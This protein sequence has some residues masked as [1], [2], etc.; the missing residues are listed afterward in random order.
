MGSS[1]AAAGPGLLAAGRCGTGGRLLAGCCG[2]AGWVP[3]WSGGTPKPL[4]PAR[5]A[6]RGARA[7]PRGAAHG[8]KASPGL[9]AVLLVAAK[10]GAAA[11]G[12]AASADLDRAAGAYDTTMSTATLLGR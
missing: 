11:W 8:A 2:A 12:M 1:L 3:G 4:L 10:S 9:D 6:G 7:P 5:Q